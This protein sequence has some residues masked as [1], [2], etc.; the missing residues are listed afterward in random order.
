MGIFS[1]RAE[2]LALVNV[3]NECW[4][5]GWGGGISGM[6][7]VQVCRWASSSYPHYKFILEYG[8]SIPINVK[9]I[10]KDIK[11]EVFLVSI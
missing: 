7:L 10:M 5:P 1:Q 8:K 9:T 4:T 11:Q 6:K 2:C 3:H